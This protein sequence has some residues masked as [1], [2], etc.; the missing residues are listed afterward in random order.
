MAIVHHKV[1]GMLTLFIA[2]Q[3]GDPDHQLDEVN[4]TGTVTWRPV[5]PKGMSQAKASEPARLVSLKPIKSLVADGQIVSLSGT[6]SEIGDV[7]GGPGQELPVMIDDTPVWWEC[8]FDVAYE[9]TAVQI[10]SMLVD[11]TEGDV[12][13]TTLVSAGGFPEVPMDDIE[14][15]IATVRSMSRAAEDAIRRAEEAASAVGQVSDEAKVAVKAAGE[16]AAAASES[17]KV[18][19]SGAD[20]VGSAEAVIEAKETASESARKADERAGDAEQAAKDAEQSASRA[21]ASAGDAAASAGDAGA[22]AGEADTSANAAAAASQKAATD[23]ASAAADRVQVGKDA[24]AA[25]TSAEYSSQHRNRAEKAAA[26][27][28]TSESAAASSAL[29]AAAD[30]ARA[31]AAAD[32]SDGAAVRAVIEKVDELTRDA[33]EKF[34]TLKEIADALEA[35]EDMGA[36]LTSQIAGKADREHTHTMVQVDGLNTALAAKAATSAMNSRPA[37][38]SGA[39]AAPSTIAGA[40]VGDWWLNTTTMELS[41]IT[42]V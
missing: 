6:V 1:T 40:V 15:V 39:G 24:E 27:A 2:D 19:K 35:Q 21:S 32:A 42:G 12:D 10:P 23:S 18:A 5:F 14:A 3:I 4:L 34:D 20:R 33:P 41:K 9:G 8:S 25:Q 36:V 16:S 30:A 11:A 37:L 31:E 13:I 28:K 29:S 26:D 38:F 22:R 17:A 7:P